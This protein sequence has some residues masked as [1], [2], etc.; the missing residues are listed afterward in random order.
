MKKGILQSR[1]ETG[2]ALSHRGTETQE[3]TYRA[4]ALAKTL[5][6]ARPP[7]P[8]PDYVDLHRVEQTARDEQRMCAAFKVPITSTVLA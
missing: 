1:G 8:P 5:H 3:N 4:K 6:V 2:P 7:S